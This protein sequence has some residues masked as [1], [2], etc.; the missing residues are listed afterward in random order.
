M[1][2]AEL[3]RT[4]DAWA[5][6]L[7]GAGVTPGSCVP[8]VLRKSPALVAALLAV[9]KTGGAYALLEPAWPVDRLA[10]LIEQLDAPVVVSEHAELAGPARTAWTPPA[11]TNGAPSGFRPVSVDA[12]HPC[13]VFFTSGTTGRAKAVL[14]PHRA[15]AR[16][17]A[18]GTFVRF[19]ENTVIPLAAAMP[20]DAF[21][22]ELWGALLPGGTSLLVDDPYL[23]ADSL[24]RGVA[25]HGVTTTWLTSSLFNM[26]V[27]ED[28]DVFAG[29]RAV[30]TGGERL[31]PEHV[32]RFLRRHPEIRLLNGYG[33]VESTVF[34]TTHRIAPEDCY[35]PD[36]IPLGRPVPETQVYVLDETRECEPGE[37]G[38]ICI[39]GNG[40]ALRYVGDPT[41]TAT[42]FPTLDIGGERVRV[43]RT[44][45]LG[46][47]DEDGLLVFRGRADRQ[48]KIR[49]HRVEPAEVER[50]IEQ[51]L[52]SVRS[53][54]VVAR[55]HGVRA[56][57]L[58]AFCVPSRAGDRLEGARTE[59]EHGLLPHE[60][61]V[62]V[63]V[64][65][66]FP[67]T[68]QG[69][70]DEQA[71]LA[72]AAAREPAVA[73]GRS[74]LDA[75]RDATERVVA[76][77]FAEV[78]GRT[79]VPLDTPFFELGGS[80][81]DAGRVCARLGGRLDRAVPLGR[82]FE[83]PT[84]AALTAW[85]ASTRPS[86]ARPLAAA[87]DASVPLTPMQTVFL[88]RHLVNPSERTGYCLLIW[89][90]RGE[91]DRAC[92]DAA[93]AA[94]HAQHE[95]LRAAYSP[96]PTPVAR[97]ADVPPPTTMALRPEATFDAA[98]GALRAELAGGLDPTAGEVWRTAVA[99]I[100]SG[101]V[102]LFG[103]VVHHI[104]FDGWSE[105]ILAR[106]LAREYDAARGAKVPAAPSAPTLAL[107]QLARA[108]RAHSAAPGSLPALI[109]ELA[110]VPDLSWPA[111][112]SAEA[113]GPPGHFELS[114]RPDVVADVDALAA[115]AGVT[116][117]VVLLSAWAR[118]L[119]DVTGQHDF[120]LGVPVAQRD[121]PLLEDA[122][123]CHITM[124]CIRVRGRALDPG[125]G[126]LRELAQVVAHALAAQDVS[127]LDLLRSVDRPRNRRPPLFQ[128]LFA[129][130]G[131]ERP[132][133]EL[134]GLRTAFLRQPYLDVPLELH[135]ELWL[136]ELGGLR[137]AV[138]YRPDAVSRTVAEDVA[139]RF[140]DSLSTVVA[141]HAT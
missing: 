136:D 87:T 44:G 18:P 127:L 34:A 67:V 10:D 85:L 56:D 20:W 77:A 93:V 51:L 13:C 42:K 73:D 119:A 120:A 36:G 37:T 97:P 75:P 139:G 121:H 110:D 95:A 137:L 26:L 35:R 82:L 81:L 104:A 129:L 70:L 55:R 88:V 64:V 108:E 48:V 74:H 90:V 15:T 112:P 27:D 65:D 33:P 78:L 126:G 122:L 68:E 111:P 79:A 100:G 32:A 83:H 63:V 17:F 23:S 94:V 14:T 21:S 113:P 9:L 45:D 11:A 2:Y 123:G 38:E 7:G 135:G 140:A 92:L 128:T 40:L 86:A 28:V 76:A 58:M 105:S 31:S 29:V 72:L 101:D 41:L 69:K 25:E 62:A 46:A 84:A 134:A 130:Q 80:S 3:D 89:E 61:P 131:T 96:D 19:D 103:C 107:A 59:L 91:L 24:R 60:R 30:L 71:L 6:A 43:Y 16:L 54:R 115:E 99:P 98:T 4:A 8:I 116:P 50:R 118:A 141:G 5:A 133:L 1:S 39:A 125:P 117:F 124:V 49:G 114:L 66:R 132:A 52:P 102:T 12:S 57:G 47:W 109:D 106:D 22:L 53:C 138:S